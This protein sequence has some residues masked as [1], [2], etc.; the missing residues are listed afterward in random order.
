ME[1]VAKLDRIDDSQRGV[2]AERPSS[3]QQ[4]RERAAD[5]GQHEARGDHE[6]VR[7]RAIRIGPV[8]LI[9]LV[10]VPW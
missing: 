4:D 8:Q 3:G 2:D 1:G 7:M 9:R 6:H 5:Q 10:A